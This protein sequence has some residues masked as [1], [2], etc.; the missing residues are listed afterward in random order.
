[1]EADLDREAS[2]EQEIEDLEGNID[3]KLMVE[4][5]AL[6]KS[7]HP[8]CPSHQVEETH[9]S[10]RPS[11]SQGWEETQGEGCGWQWWRW[12]PHTSRAPGQEPPWQSPPSQCSI[13][14]IGS[15][16]TPT[17]RHPVLLALLNGSMRS[18]YFLSFYYY[19][20]STNFIQLRLRWI[21]RV[22]CRLQIQ[23]GA[24]I[25]MS[26]NQIGGFFNCLEAL[27][28]YLIGPIGVLGTSGDSVISGILILQ[29]PSPWWTLTLIGS[30]MHTPSSM[31]RIPVKTH[32]T[33]SNISRIDTVASAFQD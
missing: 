28:K 3:I 6:G 33:A 22:V 18:E 15:G 10:C 1:M 9:C 2:D 21:L 20:C 25:F 29:L 23:W 32:A 17:R 19:I 5:I 11:C 16:L 8:V 13:L 7:G 24:H 12:T 27:R 31:W 14:R 4:D 30:H 26:S